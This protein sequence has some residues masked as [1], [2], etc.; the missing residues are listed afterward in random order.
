MNVRLFFTAIFLASISI[1]P[2]RAGT[3]W[4]VG[5]VNQFL[6]DDAAFAGCLMGVT[7]DVSG[8]P[9]T[10]CTGGYV[11]LD[12]TGELG[13]SKSISAAKVNAGQLAWVTGK[14]IYFKIDDSKK[15]NGYCLAT[16]LKVYDAP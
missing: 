10:V 5:Q 11:T 12:C 1:S 15:I 9:N 14:N 8:A 7:A 3:D 6:Y 4:L 2:A 16:H 13:T